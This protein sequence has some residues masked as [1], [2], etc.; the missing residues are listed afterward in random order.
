MKYLMA[1]LLHSFEAHFFVIIASILAAAFL[2][3]LYRNW[4]RRNSLAAL[5][6]SMNL[7]YSKDGPEQNYLESTG[8]DMFKT[9]RSRK[10]SNL[11]EVPSQA[12][13]IQV[14]DYR[15]TT[16]GGKSS[17]THNFT[18]ALI[19]CKCEMP[20]FD[21][22]PETFIYKVGELFGFKDIDL[23]AFPLFSDKYRLT[24]PDEAAVHMFFTPAR[25]AW[26]ERNLGLHVQGAPGR[27]LLFKR[28]SLLPAE[29]W[30][31][32]IEEARIFAA[33]VLK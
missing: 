4:R 11:L 26:F 29:T 2:A 5:A 6:F 24:G 19:L 32:F 18:L 28:E 7:I 20:Y 27:A 3:V 31:G 1:S 13:Q 33:E 17:H 10:A 15:Y 30:Q 22:K 21:L 9:G 8:L 12:G 25:A 23:P 16:G 14:F